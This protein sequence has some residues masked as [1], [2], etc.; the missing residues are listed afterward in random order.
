[1]TTPPVTPPV[2]SAVEHWSFQV[3][4]P[5]RGPAEIRELAG[6]PYTDLAGEAPVESLFG[7]DLA[8]AEDE[9]EA[10]DEYEPSTEAEAYDEADLGEADL[11]EEAPA[12]SHPLA[13]VF[14][15]PRLAFD[16]MAKGGW[17]TAIAVAVGAGLRDINQLTNLVFWF[18]H[19]ELTGQKLRVDQ[20]DL[21][22]EWLRI[23]DEVV[24]PA[25]AGTP[26]PAPAPAP[27]PTGGRRTSIPV[28]GLRW[29]GPPGEET[30]ELM[31]F[32][33]KV[34]ALHV[35]RSKGDFIDTLPESALDDVVPGKKARK[36]A[37]A[38]ARE[39]LAAATAALAA[40]GLA[41]SVRIGVLS[42]YRSADRQFDI[43][44]GKTTKGSGGFPFYYAATKVA[45]RSPR[46][47]G[48][49]SDKAAA[50]LA[51]YMAQYVAAPG[52]SNHQDGLALDLGTR[53]GKG[54]LVKLYKG[55]WF[56]NWL[57]ANAYTYHFTPLASEA[58][59][60]TYRPPAGASEFESEFESWPREE[61]TPT[62]VPA[63]RLEVARVPLLAGHRG[64]SPDL[65]LRWNDMPSVPAEIDV[66]VHLH[67]YSWATMTLPKHVE[68]WAGLDLGPV[69]GAGGTR[70]ARPTL[71]VL[72]RGHFTGVQ[73]GRI[74]RYTFPALTT[75]DGLST[76][77]RVAL[78][79]FSDRVGGSPPKVGRLILTAH[80]GGGAAL[81]Q[82]LRRYD[83]HEVY[84]FDGLYQDAT[85][86]AEWARRHI[87]ADRRAVEGG[88]A[89]TSA[90]R[91]FSGPSTRG[92]SLRL[93][94]ALAADLRDAPASIRDRY[95]VESS[96]LGH[97]QIARQYGWR[98]LA[99]PSADVPD[100][101]RPPPARSAAKRLSELDT[102]EIPFLPEAVEAE[103]SWE[104]G[105][106][107]DWELGESDTEGEAD[108][109]IEDSAFE[110][111]EFEEPELEQPELE[112]PELEEPELDDP[113]LDDPEME[114]SEAPPAWSEMPAWSEGEDFDADAS[115]GP[116]DEAEADLA[117][118]LAEPAQ[119]EEDPL[120][121]SKEC[122][123]RAAGLKVAVVGG[124]LGGLMAARTL[125]RWGAK[126]TVYEARSQVGGR[127][128]SDSTFARGRITEVGAEL[129]GSIHTRWCALAKEYGLSLI[130]RMDEHLYRGQQLRTR[131]IL[132]RLLTPDD[133]DQL[134]KQ[135]DVVLR[136]MAEFARAKIQS[137]KE[138][139]P[140][141]QQDLV[142]YD[143]MSVAEALEKW[144]GVGKTGPLR[145][146]MELFLVNNNVA[147]LER[148]NF[149]ALLCLIRGGQ[150]E[151]RAG[152]PV[153]IAPDPL[154]G[155]WDELEIYRCGEGCQ[156]LA[157]AIAAEVHARKGCRVI[158]E[159]G[160]RRIDLPP[161][162]GG[163]VLVTAQST[164]NTR[165]AEWLREKIPGNPLMDT[166]SYDFVVFAVPPTVW[167]DIEITPRHPKDVIG[168]MGSGAAV[169]CFSKVK[170]RFWIKDGFA[171]LGGSLE[172]GQVWEGTDNQTRSK[173]QDI[174]L[175]VF[176][177]ARTP[178]LD[179]YKKGL[180][181][182]YPA[183]PPH[184]KESGYLRNLVGEPRVVDW[185]R[186]PWIRTGYSSPRVGTV[187]TIGR[188]LNEPFQGRLFFAGE[189][190]Q[191]DHFGYM[192]GAIR[193]G[194]RAARMLVNQSCPP[195]EPV[196]V[197]ATR[198]ASGIT[199]AG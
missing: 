175:S 11:L 126:V 23:R 138:S 140:W 178:S 96:R 6:R 54:G 56:H 34:Y 32:M 24:R 148:M 67:G 76:L 73:A 91:V 53:K 188:E 82:L 109:E 57:R 13:A 182:L 172:I 25:L 74:Y 102:A 33:R 197:G 75:K 147:R 166:R 97:W 100:A 198:A 48:E 133:I 70:R 157:L 41:G 90:M 68:V 28:D 35:Q 17:S 62:A 163:G 194:E 191:M 131:V 137:G 83:P 89:P 85:P 22:R 60:W 168:L 162:S 64:R 15:L 130:S 26:A 12:T 3:D 110:D 164:K 134:G 189:H 154:M 104:A 58:W 135:M 129:V 14:S 36:D 144:F 81:L 39:M 10:Y 174:V 181:R 45:R 55:S 112:E 78:E 123:A 180:A 153:T 167:G 50:Y 184:N 118:D 105:E 173:G 177:G 143:Q 46:F 171:P 195:T 128:L 116:Y 185:S 38:K 108:P 139:Q 132:D 80:S 155:Y 165:F 152:K 136:R 192:E 27:G 142:A 158:R 2:T 141:S 151:R 77:L 122:L 199:R 42:A 87:Q 9:F 21:A 99:D 160:V 101:T 61:V 37:A 106:E 95:R 66:V 114:D 107:E 44:Q 43:W 119:Q 18:R 65:V 125:A 4:S 145:Q 47:G 146:M 30:P 176:T 196:L 179:D 92:Y 84:V 187:F 121:L 20:R 16:A 93:D 115:A 59:H 183:D 40:E 49:H 94:S 150:T 52:Y 88:A 190:T 19:P 31:A 86:L 120:A 156:R 69:D 161:R 103:D 79:R 5:F 111:S 124:G 169:K 113:E 117:P 170:D 1:M 127:V 29:L 149:L 186:Q 51:E 71:T 193:S 8:Q 63:G 98:M 7:E 159:M 72:P